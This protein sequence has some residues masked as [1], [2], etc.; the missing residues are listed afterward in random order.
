M[1]KCKL[2]LKKNNEIILSVIILVLENKTKPLSDL[3]SESKDFLCYLKIS[4]TEQQ[5]NP[6]KQTSE[7]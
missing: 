5:K 1:R 2:R 7:I 4:E 3:M 6:N